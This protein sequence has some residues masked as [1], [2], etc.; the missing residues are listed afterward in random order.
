MLPLHDRVIA[1]PARE[2]RAA[3]GKRGLT[4]AIAPKL[5]ALMDLTFTLPLAL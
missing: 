2:P 4:D 3:A 1:D 5:T